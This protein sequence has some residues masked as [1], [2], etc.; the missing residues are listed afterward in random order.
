MKITSKN[1]PYIFAKQFTDTPGGRFER[2]SQFSG[3]AFRKK[4]EIYLTKYPN[5]PFYID[6][7]GV[8]TLGASFLDEAFAKLA[9][10]LGKEQ[11]KNLIIIDHRFNGNIEE[12]IL[13]ADAV[14]LSGGN[15]PLQNKYFKEIKLKE[16]L[17]KYDGVIVG[18]SA[19]SMNCSK[20]V[21]TQPEDPE[22]FD[23][24]NYQRKISGLG[25][26]N[27]AV[28]PHMNSANEVDEQGHP[29]VMQM[30]LEDSYSIPHYGI[31]DYGFIEVKNN[32]AISYG[33]TLLLKNGKCIKLCNNGEQIV[34]DNKQ[35]TQNEYIK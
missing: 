23:D 19:G 10:D 20:V 32:K 28:M 30:C 24:V 7:E 34:L 35:L 18:Q 31:V 12:T 9:K 26:V 6:M 16:I 4:I 29:T 33:E 11:F 13:S 27:F 3:E 14:F 17:N 21:Y 25:L 1:E 2:N 5:H 22:E 8:F 15:V